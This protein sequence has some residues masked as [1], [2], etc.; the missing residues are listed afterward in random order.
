[1]FK[2]DIFFFVILYVLR[3]GYIRQTSIKICIINDFIQMM[4]QYLFGK[5]KS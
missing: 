2:D 3:I 1:M 5:I 4:A